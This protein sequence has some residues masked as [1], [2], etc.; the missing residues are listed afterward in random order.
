M[1]VALV[2]AAETLNL[3]AMVPM[4]RLAPDDVSMP[5]ALFLV[6]ETLKTASSAIVS[7]LRGS[8]L[9]QI[10]R[11]LLEPVT[12]MVAETVPRAGSDAVLSTV[13]SRVP[14]RFSLPA[15]CAWTGA[16]MPRQA[17][18]MATALHF[19]P[20]VAGVR[21]GVRAAGGKV[22]KSGG[23]PGR[24]GPGHHGLLRSSGAF[25]M[26]ACVWSECRNTRRR[27]INTSRL[28]IWLIARLYS[29][30]HTVAVP[31]RIHTGFPIYF[32]LVP[33]A[34]QKC[35]PY[36][37]RQGMPNIPCRGCQWEVVQRPEGRFL[38]SWN[39]VVVKS[40]LPFGYFVVL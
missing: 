19:M 14:F 17:R 20:G 13:A 28:A 35:L 6:E 37:R 26:N 21:C 15:S 22:R 11:T 5:K 7:M 10:P 9:P 4:S 1:P 16:S 29:G 39:I 38:L 33:R 8:D 3:P 23:N 30:Q 25:L 2:L 40:S 24:K 36:L 32:L 18:V 31:L 27:F 12:L 34:S